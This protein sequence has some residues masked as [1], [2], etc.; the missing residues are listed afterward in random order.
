LCFDGGG[1]P[2]GAAC[3][4]ISIDIARSM[5]AIP[6]IV[7]DFLPLRSFEWQVGH[8]SQAGLARKFICVM[9]RHGAFS[10][11]GNLWRRAVLDGVGGGAKAQRVSRYCA[12]LRARSMGTG[13]IRL[14]V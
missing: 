2:H 5:R 13:Q 1:L 4:S 3:E 10:V 9:A 6:K 7:T 12:S 8:E 11:A 14:T